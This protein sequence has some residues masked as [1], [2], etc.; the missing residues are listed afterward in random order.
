MCTVACIL[1]LSDSHD[2]AQL[3]YILVSASRQMNWVVTL[4]A[5]QFFSQFDH[6]FAFVVDS[7][8]DSLLLLSYF[9]AFFFLRLHNILI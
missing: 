8:V 4:R 6:Y 5:F 1:C 9:Q 2:L 7:Q 3:A